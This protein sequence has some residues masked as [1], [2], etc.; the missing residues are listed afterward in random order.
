MENERKNTALLIVIA[1]AT[2]IVAVV[3]ATFAYFA[4]T[5]TVDNSFTVNATTGKAASFAATGLEDIELNIT[6]AS[7]QKDDELYG[8]AAEDN[9]TLQ[10][11]FISADTNG[12]SCKYDILYVWDEGTVGVTP[13]N[14]T[15]NE[16]SIWS[17]VTPS[18]GFPIEGDPGYDKEFSLSVSAE[19]DNELNDMSSVVYGVTSSANET[20]LDTANKEVNISSFASGTIPNSKI[21][22]K[23]AVIKTGSNTDGLTITY[24]FVAKFYNLPLDQTIFADKVFKGH[25][26]V[27]ANC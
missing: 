23:D 21:I 13:E 27:D 3:G 10:I 25:F 19:M 6:S 11:K 12:M 17:Y 20:Y 24:T 14:A 4:S 5:T 2:L 1:I 9:G 16:T 7:M 15:N 26:E 18:V 8:I 22:I